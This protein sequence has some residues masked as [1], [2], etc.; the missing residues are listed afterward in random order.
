MSTLQQAGTGQGQSVEHTIQQLRALYADAPE[1]A[2]VALERALPRSS[3][4]RWRRRPR[5]RKAPGGSASVWAR[6]PS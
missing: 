2:K 3:R 5:R 1:M 6:S 4:R